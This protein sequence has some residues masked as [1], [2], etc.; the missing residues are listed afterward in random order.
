MKKSVIFTIAFTIISA[1]LF[2]SCEGKELDD[3]DNFGLTEKEVSHTRSIIDSSL[4][5]F[6]NEINR[7]VGETLMKYFK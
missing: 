5:K 4:V 2:F 3:N 6:K 1:N 7:S